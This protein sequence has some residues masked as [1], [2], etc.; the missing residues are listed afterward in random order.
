M[1]TMRKTSDRF[2]LVKGGSLPAPGKCWCCGAVDRDCIHWGYDEDFIGVIMLCTNCVNEA[3][4]L[5]SPTD[6][7]TNQIDNLNKIIQDLL[8]AAK[9]L[10]DALASRASGL[11]VNIDSTLKR[12][13][14]V[15]SSV[16]IANGARKG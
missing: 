3:I 1:T 6:D 10:Q 15:N 12:L 9:E 11:A 14:F 13:E 2:Y 7:K 5:F 16:S 8:S 4:G